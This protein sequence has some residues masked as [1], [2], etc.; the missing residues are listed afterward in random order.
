VERNEVHLRDYL[1]V[2]RRHGFV[3]IISF[4]LIFGSALIVSL[5]L[6]RIYEATATIEIQQ[7]TAPS[8]ISGIMQNFISRGVDQVSM[9]TICK[10]FVSNSV[11]NETIRNLKKRSLYTY[12]DLTPEFLAPRIS[13]K[14]VPDTKIIEVKIKMRRD[15]GGSQRAAKIANELIQVIQDQRGEKTDAEIVRRQNFINEKIKSIESQIGNSDQ[16]IKS[17]LKNKGNTIAWSAR[18]D[19]IFNRMAN[20]T[21]LKEM[22]ESLLSAEQKI[23]NELK[24]RL[25][26]EPEFIEYS[27]T[28]SQDVLWEKYKTDLADINLK[29]IDARAE[30][31]DGYSRVKALQAQAEQI[32]NKIKSLA[33]ETMKVSAKTESRN[34]THQTLLNQLIESELNQIVYSARCDAAVKLLKQL[35]PEKEQI[36]SEMPQ[37]QYELD[38][39]NREVGYKMDVYKDLLT[40]KVEAEIMALDSVGDNTRIKGGIE[41]IDLAQPL[42]RP[43]SPR[44]KFIVTIASIVGFTVGLTMAFLTEYIEKV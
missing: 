24:T 36:L 2:I 30:F 31:G 35:N 29:L 6:P 43:V 11:L 23:Y 20:L 16:N 33:Q 14:I 9:E 1:A 8:G 32:S 10:R 12:R 27:R 7:S 19:Y 15:E 42:S 3:I 37:N 13:A 26:K 34:P 4:L 5:Y 44:I 38:K 21:D 22:N 17:F 39:M 25:S 41:V 18:A 40:K 28:L